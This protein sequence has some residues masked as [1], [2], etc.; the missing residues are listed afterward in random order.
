V[1]KQ[2]YAVGGPPVRVE[3][4]FLSPSHQMLKPIAPRQVFVFVAIAILLSSS[5]SCNGRKQTDTQTTPTLSAAPVTN[6]PMSPLSGHTEL[7]WVQSDGSRAKLADFRGKILVLDF[8]ATWCEPCRRSIPQLIALQRDYGPKGLQIVGLNVGG[9]DDRIKVAGF[10][11]ELDIKYPLGFPDKA[12]TDF[13][14][15]GDQTI[16]QTFVFAGGDQPVKRFIGYEGSTGTELV[17]A[18]REAVESKQ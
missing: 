13:F 11:R 8:Y 5:D 7:G 18:V 1:T 17:K 12:L 16:P 10:A 4:F 6:F 2:S 14:F 3:C 15:S 9:P